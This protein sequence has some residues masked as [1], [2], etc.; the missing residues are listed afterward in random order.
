M[1]RGSPARDPESDYL[2]DGAMSIRF[3]ISGLAV[4]TG[5][6]VLAALPVVAEGHTP[7]TTR[8]CTITGTSGSDYLVGT[9]GRDVICGSWGNDTIAGSS[10]D[11][12]IKGGPGNDSL[13]GDAGNDALY[14]GPGRDYLWLRDNAHD[15]GYGGRGYDRARRDPFKDVLGSVEYHN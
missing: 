6:V 5:L 10:G 2:G 11:D 12:I 7:D 14:G 8:P 3:L 13:L 1:A 9:T 15:H 4:L